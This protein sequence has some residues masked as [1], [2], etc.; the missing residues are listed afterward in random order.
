MK[1]W[2]TL[3]ELRALEQATAGRDGRDA[4]LVNRLTAD[5]QAAYVLLREI[6]DSY[7]DLIKTVE[8]LQQ[9]IDDLEQEVNEL[10]AEVDLPLWLSV[11]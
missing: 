1:P 8:D 5:L 6:R 7:G 3:L 2:F 4:V 10:P 11:S 9:E